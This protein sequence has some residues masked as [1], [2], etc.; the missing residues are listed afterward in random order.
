MSKTEAIIFM[1]IT[2]LLGIIS[3]GTLFLIWILLKRIDM[4]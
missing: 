2:V 3:T 1:A 4:L